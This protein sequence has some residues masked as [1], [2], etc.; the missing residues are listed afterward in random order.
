MRKSYTGEYKAKAVIEMLREIKSV[1][2]LASELEVHPN[3]LGKW[4]K[5]VQEALPGI[6]ED[7][8]R[9]GDKENEELRQQIRE[10]YAE[11][12]ELTIQLS[13]FKK[14]SGIK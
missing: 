6:L 5:E 2:Q 1:S 11:I 12:G 4:K 8:R 10:L 3:Q 14:K 7:G 13:W 9:K